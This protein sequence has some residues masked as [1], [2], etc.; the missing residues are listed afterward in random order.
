MFDPIELNLPKSSAHESWK[1]DCTIPLI[2]IYIVLSITF[3]VC[4][5]ISIAKDYF[6]NSYFGGVVLQSS[7]PTE[8][9]EA[10]PIY[11]RS[12]VEVTI[13]DPPPTYQP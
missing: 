5:T 13:E 2:Q 10:L 12:M 8:P 7:A 9:Q 6:R 3:F 1:R 11:S 4:L